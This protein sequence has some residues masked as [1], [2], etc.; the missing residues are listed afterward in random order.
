VKR[1]DQDAM[2]TLAKVGLGC[3]GV[4]ALASI[5]VALV[6]PSVL[7]EARRVMG[8]VGRMQ[9]SQEAL[10][11]MAKKA[12]WKRPGKDALSAER[13]DRFFA[14][15]K[16][17]DAVRRTTELD[18]DR[19]PRGHVRSLEELRAVPGVLQDVSEIVAAEMDAFV[20]AGMPP[21]EYHWIERLVYERWRGPLRRAGSYPLARRAVAAEIDA[22][23]E[24]EKDGQVRGRL[25]AVAAELRAR[26]PDAPEGFD[27]AIHALLLS[28]VEE[29]ERWSLD[30]LAAPF[31]TVPR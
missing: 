21:A 18:L 1:Y 31:V 9:R 26:V 6:A 4:A 10:D 19:L 23:A 20:E 15:R 29:V 16:R 17:V 3:A 5:G 7:R 24:A 25:R 8:P 11:A 14:V 12:A 22:A 28:R 2:R 30:D 27:P 13:L